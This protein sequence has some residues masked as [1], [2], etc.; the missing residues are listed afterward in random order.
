MK[1][2]SFANKIFGSTRVTLRA[3]GIRD[4]N[5][6]P[7]WHAVPAARRTG[8]QHGARRA[9]RG[10]A[11]GRCGARGHA[12]K[13]TRHAGKATACPHAHSHAGGGWVGHRAAGSS[14]SSP[15][16][17]PQASSDMVAGPSSCKP[18]WLARLSVSLPL[19][20][21]HPFPEG[22]GCRAACPLQA[23]KMQ[24]ST[25]RPSNWTVWTHSLNCRISTAVL[26]ASDCVVSAS[27]LLLRAVLPFW[28]GGTLGNAIFLPR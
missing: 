1:V 9:A 2:R 12:G 13:A 7:H 27:S 11:R 20:R 10:A 28:R 24:H 19:R 16:Q 6:P 14:S 4:K 15:R 18:L 5:L 25:S 3:W 17:H 21:R 22:P 26:Q 8:Q 23:L